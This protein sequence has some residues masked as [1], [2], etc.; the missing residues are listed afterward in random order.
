MQRRQLLLAANVV[1]P[2][3]LVGFSSVAWSQIQNMNDAINKAGRQR[4]LSQRMAKSYLAQGLG[5]MESQAEKTLSTSISVF[6]RQLV[7]LKV[8]APRPDIK[9]TYQQL[10][11]KWSDY[12]AAL[13]GTAPSQQGAAEVLS[14]SND[15]LALSNQGTAQLEALAN[16]PAAHLVN[17][18]GRQR[19]LSQRMASQ[20]LAA[21]WNINTPKAKSEMLKA[22]DEFTAALK[23]LKSAP[24]TTGRILQEMALADQQLVFFQVALQKTSSTSSGKQSQAEVFLTSERI[25]QVMDTITGLYAQVT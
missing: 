5:V 6:D 10:E 11:A 17:V 20:Y 19:M 24:E 1:I 21:S 16:K 22:N 7:E 4:M 9:A 3:S 23:E 8:Y 14:L 18:A 25:L 12:K 2:S 13:V 15:I